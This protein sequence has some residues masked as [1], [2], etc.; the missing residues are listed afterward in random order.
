MDELLKK[1]SDPAFI[2][3]LITAI[4]GLVGSFV[5][6]VAPGEKEFEDKVFLLREKTSENLA[7]SYE[8]I[9]DIIN[10]PSHQIRGDGSPNSDKLGKH[11]NKIVGQN[12]I[13]VDAVNIFEKVKLVYSFFL[14]SIGIGGLLVVLVFIFPGGKIYY[15]STAVLVIIVQFFCIF[16]L[17]KWD[18]KL[19]TYERTN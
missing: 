5:H 13:Y 3:G 9:I 17:R 4:F 16:C 6:K 11:S 7:S 10:R 12:F 18:D 14:I 1:I 15:T 8:E 2:T 19:R